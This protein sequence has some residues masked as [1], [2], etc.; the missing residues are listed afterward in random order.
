MNALETIIRDVLVVQGSLS[1]AAYMEI[2]LQHPEHGYYRTREPL[3]RTGDFITAPEISQ[4]FGEMIGVWCAEAWHRLGDPS[5]FALVELGP[6]HGTMMQDILR[7]TAHVGGF[8]AAKQLYLLDSDV[9]LRRKQSEVLSDSKPVHI[10][11]VS[12]LPSMPVLVV[13]NEFFDALP[14]RLFEKTFQGWAERM[15][16]L[17]QKGLAFALRP[18]ADVEMNLIPASL[19]DAVPGT[20]F[21][22]SPEAQIRM[23]ELA[24]VLL[25]RR[26]AALIIDYGYTARPGFAT[27][28]A[29]SHHASADIFERPGEVD[30]TA[31]V[32]FTALAD[33]ARAGGA[34][35][36][37]AVGQGAFLRNCGIEIRAEAL[38]KNA[39]D[40]QRTAID[41]ALKRLIDDDQMGRLFKVMEIGKCSDLTTL[42]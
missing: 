23:R 1:V 36:S 35:V 17:D 12:Q 30:L 15:V 10:D 8:H 28:Q 3:G 40:E 41:S 21:E 37:E 26:G 2:A 6:G 34:N 13:A 31:H 39:T 25:S 32:D 38:K 11:A 18:L 33:A 19:R 16:T 14:V 22:F 42:G 5:P 7:A 29:V 27:V 4:M 24:R 9:V 20:C